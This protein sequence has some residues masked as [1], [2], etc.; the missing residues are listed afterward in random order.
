ALAP[1]RADLR[2][3]L[4]KA[5]Q[6]NQQGAA[7]YAEWKAV[8]QQDEQPTLDDLYGL[9]QAALDADEISECLQACQRVL[10]VQ[11]THGGAHA[12]MGKALVAQG[13]ANSAIEHLRRATELAPAQPAAWLV[14][15][16]LLRDSGDL[17]A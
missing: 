6:E 3:L 11:A 16:E 4:A 17:Q 15:A 1:E 14:L 8:L 13:D 7:A 10:A 12:L 9:A 5:L 2:R